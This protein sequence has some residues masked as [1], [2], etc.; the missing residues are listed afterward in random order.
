[1]SVWF[2]GENSISCSLDRVNQEVANTGE[3][4]AGVVGRMP[5]LINVE[6]VDAQA[7]AL[8]IRTN[9]GLM[10]RTNISTRTPSDSVLI[11]FDEEYNA[12]SKVT[13]NSH[14]L[15]EFIANDQGVSHRLVIR[16]VTAP[17]LLGFF[18]RTFGSAKMGKAFLTAHKGYLEDRCSE[19]GSATS[20]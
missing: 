1:M 18:Y 9:E 5:G 20:S 16:D 6:L 4:F 12:G 19:G 17:G 14:F 13:T 3:Y 2:E 10:R 7:D 15:H 11:E 8:T